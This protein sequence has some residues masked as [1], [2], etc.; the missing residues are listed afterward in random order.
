MGMGLRGSWVFLHY[1]L[2]CEDVYNSSPFCVLYRYKAKVAALY[3]LPEKL[4]AKENKRSEEMLSNQMLSGIPEVDLGLEWA[5]KVFYINHIIFVYSAKF[6]NIEETELA[7]QKMIEER[8]KKTWV[9][10]ACT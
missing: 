1:Q 10:D 4:M 5:K 2:F 9:Q 3:A 8:H 7:K 6:K